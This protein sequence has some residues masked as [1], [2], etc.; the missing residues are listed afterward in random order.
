[1]PGWTPTAGRRCSFLFLHSEHSPL[2]LDEP[3]EPLAP[4]QA[5]FLCNVPKRAG[6]G[7]AIVAGAGFS[8]M[9]VRVLMGGG[10]LVYRATVKP[11]PVRPHAAA[12]CERWFARSAGRPAEV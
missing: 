10:R 2:E 4:P 3:D 6:D 8:E 7:V 9:W 12:G 5:H 1:M 11:R